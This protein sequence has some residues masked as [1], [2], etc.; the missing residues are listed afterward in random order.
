MGLFLDYLFHGF[1]SLFLCHGSVVYFE[2][3]CYDTTRIFLLRIT[4]MCTFRA[5]K[6]LQLLLAIFKKKH[7]YTL[8]DITLDMFAI[9]FFLT[10]TPQDADIVLSY[11]TG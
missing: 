2:V 6:S 3:R 5:V 9:L 8:L 1:T 4:F 10:L 11:F 7:H